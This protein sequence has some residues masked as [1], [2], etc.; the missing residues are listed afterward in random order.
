MGLTQILH[1]PLPLTSTKETVMSE[2]PEKENLE[3]RE[4]QYAKPK[5]HTHEPLRNLTGTGPY[6][7][8]Q[9]TFN[10]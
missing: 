3:E 5:L 9:P 7:D 8:N 4:E 10:D 2:Q 6:P 1:Q